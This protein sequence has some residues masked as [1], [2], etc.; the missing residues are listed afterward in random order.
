MKRFVVLHER[1]VKRK[2]RGMTE[3]EY[4]IS[5]LAHLQPLLKKRRQVYRARRELAERPRFDPK[6]EY[7]HTE[8][9][10]RFG[11]LDHAM[12]NFKEDLGRFDNDIQVSDD[13]VE[14]FSFHDYEK[15]GGMHKAD[16]MLKNVLSGVDNELVES[17]KELLRMY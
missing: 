4:D 7:Q 2:G 17:Y 14:E 15:P 12:A 6:G 11:H 3:A 13:L 9:R 10:R 16:D 1:N 5:L 8:D